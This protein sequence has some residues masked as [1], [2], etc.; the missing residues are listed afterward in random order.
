MAT[1]PF[2]GPAHQWEAGCSA[3]V[4]IPASGR[5]QQHPQRHI[6]IDPPVLEE[7][8]CIASAV[9]LL[10]TDSLLDKTGGVP[11]RARRRGGG[12]V[13]GIFV[14]MRLHDRLFVKEK[15]TGT[16]LNQ[17]LPVYQAK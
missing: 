13:P 9:Q 16:V 10:H 8:G 4:V 1:G 5:L 3:S 6:N 11:V 7:V 2:V 14:S 17:H 15:K 12:K